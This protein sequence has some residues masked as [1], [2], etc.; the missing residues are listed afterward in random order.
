M[1]QLVHYFA[2]SKKNNGG[3]PPVSPADRIAVQDAL[4]E[5]IVRFRS[6]EK[7]FY[8]LIGN[9]DDGL[10]HALGCSPIMYGAIMYTANILGLQ[11]KRGGDFERRSMTIP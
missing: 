10:M 6:K 9:N 1:I 3:R 5:L 2:L 4:A 7:H 11:K 8:N